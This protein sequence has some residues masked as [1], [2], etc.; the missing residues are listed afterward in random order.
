MQKWDIIRIRRSDKEAVREIMRQ[1]WGSEKMAVHET[2]FDL[3]EQEGFLARKAQEVVGLLTYRMINH[4]EI[5]LL[6][7]DSF[8]ENQ[9]IGSALLDKLIDFARSQSLKS[10]CLVTTNDNMRALQFYQKRGFTLCALHCHAVA[11][12]RKLKTEIPLFAENGIAIEHELE[13]KR[14]IRGD[15]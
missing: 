4:S 8:H 12:A 5:E 15:E 2:I 1:R 11:R 14:Q 13:L 3:T 7:L 9:G 10:I 6:S